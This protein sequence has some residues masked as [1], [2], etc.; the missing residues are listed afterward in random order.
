MIIRFIIFL[1]IC[2]AFLLISGNLFKKLTILTRQWPI[3]SSEL[4]IILGLIF[5]I[6]FPYLLS[7][8]FDLKLY[9]FIFG[10]LQASVI[11]SMVLISIIGTK[12]PKKKLLSMISM[13]SI[14][15]GANHPIF[16]FAF[17]L[18]ALIV[19]IGYLIFVSTVYFTNPF[20]SQVAIKYI[21]L[22]TLSYGFLA[23]IPF[24]IPNILSQLTSKNIDNDTRNYVFC[25]ML[26]GIIPSL[27]YLSIPF[28]ILGVESDKI[29]FAVGGVKLT[30]FRMLLIAFMLYF[31][32]FIVI[33]HAHGMRAYKRARIADYNNI[34]SWLDR[35][36]GAFTH[37]RHTDDVIDKLTNIENE[38]EREMDHYKD[39][40]PIIG[41]AI[42]IESS[43]SHEVESL[44]LTAD[45]IR[46]FRELDRRFVYYDFLEEIRRD[47][48]ELITAY[49]H[50]SDPDL[51][52]TYSTNDMTI[53]L[54]KKPEC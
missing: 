5:L 23:S 13:H 8:F 9:V 31:V 36:M 50:I 18:W 39:E 7:G 54:D 3:M 19:L 38:F 10:G 48:R 17:L 22:A 46:D 44:G 33:P 40:N 12:E 25:S 16:T 21:M 4:V 53:L 6:I 2:F 14:E 1:I 35:V 24:L 47:I 32:F 49:K 29:I 37:P 43:E 30:T 51:L 15:L 42:E 45:A 28:L 11:L 34:I 26:S 20:G 41:V 52:P 27:I